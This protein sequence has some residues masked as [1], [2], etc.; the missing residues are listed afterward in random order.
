MV[1]NELAVGRELRGY[2]QQR[3]MSETE[4]QQA[5][6]RIQAQGQISRDV[7]MLRR[8][9]GRGRGTGPGASATPGAEEGMVQEAIR[10]QGLDPSKVANATTVN[11]QFIRYGKGRTVY[12]PMIRVL[13]EYAHAVRDL[14][15][16]NVSRIRTWAAEQGGLIAAISDELSDDRVQNLEAIRN[17]ALLDVN[18]LGATLT[19]Q[20]K[21]TQLSAFGAS[22]W[23]DRNTALQEIRGFRQG[24]QARLGESVAGI[25]VPVQEIFDRNLQRTRQ[26]INEEFGPGPAAPRVRIT[27]RETGDSAEIRPT[28]PRY[29]E[30]IERARQRGH[31]VE[32]LPD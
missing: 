22:P 13:D 32:E 28:H 9:G 31:R 8:R 10:I 5:L 18:R 30:T 19:P 16:G 11:Q 3:D 23:V 21:Q 4:H 25:P 2:Q 27:H 20:E 15:E 14:P 12:S 29:L 6:E 7:A 1:N 24:V 17:R 26:R